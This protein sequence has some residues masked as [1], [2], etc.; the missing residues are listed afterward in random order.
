MALLGAS[1]LTWTMT[2]KRLNAR[3]ALRLEARN[4]AEALAE[5]GFSQIRQKFETRSTFSLNPYGSDSLRM[6]AS[7]FWSGSNVVN[8]LASGTTDDGS[9]PLN[10][11]NTSTTLELV[12]GTI[13]N[14]VTGSGNLFYV[15]PADQNNEFDSL[16]GKWIFR[17]DVSVI[18]KA[19]V[20]PPAGSSG[21]PLVSYVAERISV[22]GA[23]LFA[24]A[25]FYNMDLEIFNGPTMNI[26][27]PVHANGN[28]YLYPDAELNFR[29][30]VT[31]T[32]NIYHAKKPGDTSSDGG[33]AAGRTGSVN[34]PNRSNVLTNLRTS[35]VWQDTTHGTGTSGT[36]WDQF[37]ANASQVWNGNLQTTAHGVQNYTPVA[38]GQYIEDPTPSNG[39]DNSVNTGRALIEPTNYP[40]TGDASYD[41]KMEI[42]KQKYSNDA[43]LYITVTPTASPNLAT[44]VVVTS[45]SR[46]DPTKNKSIT[47]PAASQFIK[48]TKYTTTTLSGVTTVTGGMYDQHRALGQDLVELDMTKLR[49]AVAQMQLAAGSRDATKAFANLE[50]TDSTGIVYVEV[51]G[52]PTTRLV[53]DPVDTTLKAGSTIAA[54]NGLNTTTSVRV[55]NGVGKVPSYA[56][57]GSPGLTIATNAPIYIKGHYNADGTASTSGGVNP[58]TDIETDELPAAIVADAITVLSPSFVDSTSRSTSSPAATSVEISAAFLTGIAPTNKNGS[59]ATSGGAHNIVRF[60]EN[61]G[62]DSTWLRGSLVSL[63]ESRVFTTAHGTSSY[64]SPPA[65][66]WG[67]NNLFRQGTYPPGTPRV[68]SYRRVDF[69][70]LTAAQYSS[71]RTSFNWAP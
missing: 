37:R 20:N 62:G 21:A 22:R 45:R 6:P 2:E 26:S 32:G 35:G 71:V 56:G 47:V 44:D 3:N 27:G 29:G 46:S 69:T 36:A 4:A 12:G 16:K 30:Q 68:L 15:D 52:G 11:M 23:P 61:W 1:L 25:I 33:T 51:A 42:E 40:A 5:F 31:A 18:A 64:Y 70:D 14:V 34:F 59:G 38:V 13:N 28:L 65:R 8:T 53:D 39:V 10:G 57:G 19:T 54:T 50:T 66:N 60:L 58:A 49:D 55:V 9:T 17:R 7:S 41:Q 63:F 24:H 48:Y 67:F 43:G